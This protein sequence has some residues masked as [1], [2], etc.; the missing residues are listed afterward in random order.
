M[1]VTP[2][3]RAPVRILRV[4]VPDRFSEHCG[5]YEYLLREHGLDLASIAPRVAAFERKT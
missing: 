2:A 5:S 1:S 3:E 4:G